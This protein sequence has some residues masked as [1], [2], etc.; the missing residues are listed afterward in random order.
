MTGPPAYSTAVACWF[1]ASAR[2][3]G[4]GRF[5]SIGI[6]GIICYYYL[7]IL[8]NCPWCGRSGFDPGLCHCH[9]RAVQT[10]KLEGLSFPAW[11]LAL[12]S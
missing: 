3:A 12:L 9:T 5:N 2:R 7:L 11:R 10:G 4:I 1:R 6:S 8:L